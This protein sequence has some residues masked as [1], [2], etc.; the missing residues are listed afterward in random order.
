MRIAEARVHGDVGLNAD[1][2]A[3]R[4][5]FVHADIVRLHG[6]PGIVER[7]WPFVDV[8]DT[9]VPAPVRKEIAARQAPHA[10]VEL[11]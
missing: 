9:V 7:R 2:L 6:I 4:H 5:E 3:Q 8:A 1:E 11:F 10:G